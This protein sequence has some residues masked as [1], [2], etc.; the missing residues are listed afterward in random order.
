[1]FEP[2]AS[3]RE[4]L[5]AAQAELMRALAGAGPVPP[6]FDPADLAEEAATLAN[7]RRR[8]AGRSRPA[9][10][11]A[12]GRRFG[13][14]FAAFAATHKDAAH[15]CV[16]SAAFARWF[17]GRLGDEDVIEKINWQVGLRAALALTSRQT[18]DPPLS[19]DTK[20]DLEQLEALLAAIVKRRGP[21]A[22]EEPRLKVALIVGSILALG[23]ELDQE[24]ILTV[25]RE[26][27]RELPTAT[28]VRTLLDSA[29]AL[30]RVNVAVERVLARVL[31]PDQRAPYVLRAG[32]DPFLGRNLPRVTLA[33]SPAELTEALAARWA[34]GFALGTEA[35]VAARAIAASL[36][37]KSA[38]V[39]RGPVDPAVGREPLVATALELLLLQREAEEDLVRD[40]SLTTPERGRVAQRRGAVLL[41]L[42]PR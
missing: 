36:V 17:E 32:N 41:E 12:L 8:A 6:G 39:H 19:P 34:Q 24:Q 13:D 18:D 35:R 38:R 7:K 15:A 42:R 1:M 5:G 22:M 9:L 21:S 4:R 16:D 37:R 3:V 33:G 26:L 2:S 29:I 28:A 31:R 27:G 11:R 14:H 30:L 20:A 23:V 25:R 40:P 10:A